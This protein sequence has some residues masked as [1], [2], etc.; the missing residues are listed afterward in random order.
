MK[1]AALAPK[2]KF[3]PL[4][5]HGDMPVAHRAQAKGLILIGVLRVADTDVGLFQQPHDGRDHLLT[6]QSVQAHVARDASANLG[7]RP[8]EVGQAMKLGL[9]ANGV[10]LRMVD[11]LFATLHVATSGLQVTV[12]MRTDPDLLPSRWDRQLAD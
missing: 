11:V 8:D 5:V 9:L 1:L 12:W 4:A 6:R 7:Q 10:P 3:H 2:P